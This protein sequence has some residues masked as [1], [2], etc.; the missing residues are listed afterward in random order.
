MPTVRLKPGP[1]STHAFN[2]GSLAAMLLACAV[3]SVYLWNGVLTVVELTLLSVVLLPPYLLIVACVL[4][5]WLGF[6]S[7]ARASGHAK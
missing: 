1:L 7:D 6:S 4:G 5:V 2:L 3:F